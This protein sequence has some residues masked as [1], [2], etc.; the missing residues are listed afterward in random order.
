[1]TQNSHDK[2]HREEL[3][4]RIEDCRLRVRRA[5]LAR[6]HA[7]E[8]DFERAPTDEGEEVRCED[9]LDARSVIAVGVLQ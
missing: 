7:K 3:K 1:M 4:R 8:R 5:R 2:I 6:N 9:E